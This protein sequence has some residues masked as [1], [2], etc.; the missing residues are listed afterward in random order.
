[1]GLRE[2]TL[3]LAYDSDEDD[4]L[5]DF[6]IPALGQSTSYF[7]LAGFFS[8][9]ALAIAARGISQFIKNGGTMKLVVGAKLRKQDIEA[10]EAGSA[11]KD[12]IVTDLMI[13]D[14][15]Y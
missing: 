7:R 5:S 12:E 14:R 8:S 11:N 3:K 2:I 15:F 10:I 1:M 6:Y 13:K 9:T 4:I